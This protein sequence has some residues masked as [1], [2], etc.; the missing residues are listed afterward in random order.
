[1]AQVQARAPGTLPGQE[2][3]GPPSVLIVIVAKDGAS[4][5]PRCLSGLASQDHARVAVIAVD[6]GSTDG[7]ADLLEQALGSNRVIR[8]DHNSGFAAAVDRALAS[9]LA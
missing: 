4:W 2:L 8:L 6:N 5:V 7:S 3:V 9:D 1:M